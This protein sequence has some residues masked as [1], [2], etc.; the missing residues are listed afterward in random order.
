MI[1]FNKRMA[2]LLVVVAA[3]SI[4]SASITIWFGVN[5]Q[6]ETKLYAG[7]DSLVRRVSLPYSINRLDEIRQFIVKSGGADDSVRVYVNDF[8]YITDVVK[9]KIFPTGLLRDQ[10]DETQVMTVDQFIK[11]YARSLNPGRTGAFDAS[12]ALEV[13]WNHVV[14]EIGNMEG[15]CSFGNF[16]IIVNGESL[17]GFPTSLIPDQSDVRSIQHPLLDERFH[18]A[19]YS[20]CGRY[21]FQFFLD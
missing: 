13:G 14:V 15:S 5:F 12:D 4:L 18:E 11:Q 3:S 21:V 20:I 2:L 7:S 19:T 8:L 16:D 1:G 17:P 6:T 9:E 10:K